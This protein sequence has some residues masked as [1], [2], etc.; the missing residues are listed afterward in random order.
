[1]NNPCITKT[2]VTTRQQ[3]IG[4]AERDLIRRHE[5]AM[6]QLDRWDV[7]RE[8]RPHTPRLAAEAERSACDW[9]A[10]VIKAMV[11]QAGPLT[12]PRTGTHPMA[13]PI[14]REMATRVR[15]HIHDPKPA[16]A[17]RAEVFWGAASLAMIVGAV[18]FAWWLA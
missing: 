15:P 9:K 11:D 18:A 2:V 4:R 3:A 7:A 10:P 14:S 17:Y 16:P 5:A 1:M 13:V 8:L 6:K 12:G